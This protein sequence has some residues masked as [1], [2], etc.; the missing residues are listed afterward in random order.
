LRPIQ[1]APT[2]A[3]RARGIRRGAR[4]FAILAALVVGAVITLEG[5]GAGGPGATASTDHDLTIATDVGASLRFVPDRP[6][7]SR[8]TLRVL[9][10]N[11]SSEPHNLTFQ[12][13]DAR[14]D[15]IVGPGGAQL[16]QVV[17]PGPGVYPFVCTIHPDMRGE[18]TI[19]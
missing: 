7:A 15:T 4:R 6:A 17:T 19:S 9:F 14:T 16:L 3:E 18:L 1:P 2:S 11:L 10:R 13:I 8:A 5:C 12:G